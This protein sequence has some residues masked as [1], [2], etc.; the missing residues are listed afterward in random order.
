[1]TPSYRVVYFSSVPR[2][3]TLLSS[4]SLGVDHVST[5]QTISYA[6]VALLSLSL[7]LSLSPPLSLFFHTWPVLLGTWWNK[8]AGLR[9]THARRGY[10]ASWTCAHV[11][12]CKVKYVFFFFGRERKKEHVGVY[13]PIFGSRM[14]RLRI[15]AWI[16]KFIRV[17]KRIS[18]A[19]VVVLFSYE[20]L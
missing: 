5:D 9:I 16:N 12:S 6:A 7:S 14:I 2:E 10:F 17:T 4:T 1:L 13:E 8:F 19:Q 15:T 3:E 11:R 20:I 18:D